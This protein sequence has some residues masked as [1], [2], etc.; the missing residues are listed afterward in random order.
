MRIRRY[1][2]L[3]TAVAVALAVGGPAVAQTAKTAP[4]GATPAAVSTDPATTSATYGDWVLRC[5]KVGDG[6]KAVRL[7]EVA[8]VMQSTQKAPVAEVAL[9]RLPN[10]ASLHLTAVLPPSVSFLGGVQ[11][12]TVEKTPRAADLQWRRCLPGGCFA[13]GKPADDVLKAWRGA[14]Q[15]GRLSFKD[16]GDR[17]VSLPLSFRGLA[18][19]LDAMNKS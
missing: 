2:E 13:E 12:A 6:D 7:C 4:A 19:A 11:I 14:D 9:G 1:G 15:P 17:D 8:Q 5:Q 3:A 10:D 18:Q 16:A